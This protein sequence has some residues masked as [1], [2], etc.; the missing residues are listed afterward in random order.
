MNR[1]M[2]KFE[3]K[4]EKLTLGSLFDGAGGFPLAGLRQEIIPVWASEIAE[5][6]IAVTK[7]H[8]P[9]MKHLG[10]ITKINGAN[11]PP[12]AIITFGS[13]CQDWSVAGQRVGAKKCTNEECEEVEINFDADECPVC[14]SLTEVTRSGLFSEA[15]RIIDEMR[16]A[17]NGK[18]PQWAIWENVPGALTSGR[19]KGTD[20]KTVIEAFTKT[21]IPMPLSGRWADA[22]LVRSDGVNIAWR[23]FNA[24]GWELSQRRKRIFLV[25]SYGEACPS[26]I[27]FLEKGVFGDIV[28]SGETEKTSSATLRNG[29][30]SPKQRQ[31]SLADIE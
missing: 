29:V 23:V 13:P 26:E 5:K 14:G 15:I 24:A 4:S 7:L 8:F 30:E 9:E 1:A 16:D 25:A 2:A 19:P 17:T 27:L 21:K 28:T 11:I 22:G 20:F 3:N 10:D 12:V 18:Y 6:A 31:L